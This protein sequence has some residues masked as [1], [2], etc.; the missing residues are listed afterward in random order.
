MVRPHLPLILRLAPKTAAAS[1]A[2]TLVVLAADWIVNVWLM[3]G[4][5]PYNMVTTLIVTLLVAPAAVLALLVQNERVTAARLQIA[6][7]NEAR[8]AAEA[9]NAARTRFMAN[10]S[11]EFRTPI[12]GI[13]GYT[14]LMMEAA[15]ADGRSQDVADHERVVAAATRLLTLINDVLDLA[16]GEAGGMTLTLAPYD[17]R[18]LLTDAVD[19]VRPAMAARNNVVTLHFDE[20]LSAGV[21]DAFRLSQCVLNLLSNAA[22]FTSGGRVSVHARRDRRDGGDWLVVAVSDTGVGIPADRLA[23]VF[24]PFMQIESLESQHHR[25]AGLGLAITRQILALLGGTID[26][27]STPDCGSCFTLRVPLVASLPESTREL[28]EAA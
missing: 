8:A 3:P 26:V 16:R 13:I 19:L 11:H 7:A 12:N 22:K 6:H 15:L 20:T 2:I 1:A 9:A 18:K 28:A 24:E 27:T 5:T 10:T 17:V 25:G 4:V 21:S 23:L 14:E